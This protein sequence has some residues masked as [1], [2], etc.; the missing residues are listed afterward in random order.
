MVNVASGGTVVIVA[1]NG[2]NQR[3]VFACGSLAL[4]QTCTQLTQ[5]MGPDSRAGRY[6]LELNPECVR[7]ASYIH[8]A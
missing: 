7:G 5:Y 4:N 6:Y 1:V 8:T 2:W 3:S